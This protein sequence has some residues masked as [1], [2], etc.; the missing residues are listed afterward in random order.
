LSRWDSIRV[1]F[2]DVNGGP[3]V[4]EPRRPHPDPQV[5]AAERDPDEA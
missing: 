2:R 1:R 3:G 4:L 5:L